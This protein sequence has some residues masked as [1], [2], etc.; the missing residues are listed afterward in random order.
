VIEIKN[1]TKQ[2]NGVPIL[3]GVNARVEAGE[4]ISII[5]SSGTGKST[6]LRCLN[7]LETP[8]GGEILFK[9]QNILSAGAN[10][11]TVREKV[12]MV[13]QNFNLF[14]HLMVAENLML[15]PVN[16]LGK[17]RREAHEKALMLLDMVGL[18]DK[19]KAFPAELSGGQKQRVAI[20][21]ALAM[22]PEVILFDE[23]TSALDPTM[24]DEVLSIMR[25]LA[26]EGLTML[27]VTHEMRFAREVSSRVFY[28]DEGVVFEEG[29]P[30]QIFEE[31]R[32]EKTRSFV[33]KLKSFNERITSRSFDFPGLNSKIT[34]F[35]Y[36]Q[37]LTPK[38]IGRIQLAVEELVINVL[39]PGLNGEI[40]IELAV[41]HREEND[42]IEVIVSA[43]T[44]R[45][46]LAESDN[47]LSLDILKGLFA[48]LISYRQGE[49]FFIKVVL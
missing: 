26:K 34:E 39:M 43:E 13:F 48:S 14:N 37:N 1:L 6:M 5:G 32:H 28:M 46:I 7:L 17:S 10:I 4:V 36:R 30:K 41:Y 45:D 15:G 22:D 29:P 31:P 8:D 9:G 33:L 49:M 27:V 20:T 21:R 40:P 35:G 24:V 18:L 11:R 3:K 19:A 2:F 44:D 12:G 23:P 16:L 47:K 42:E 25:R 38:Q